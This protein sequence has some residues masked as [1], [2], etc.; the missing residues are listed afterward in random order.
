MAHDGSAV[1]DAAPLPDGA[2]SSANC[3]FAVSGDRTYPMTDGSSCQGS[4]TQHNG[5][6]DYTINMATGFASPATMESLTFGL[7]VT[8]TSP[9]AVGDTWTVGQDGR[10]GNSTLTVIKG[11]TG[12]LWGTSDTDA[13][14]VKGGTTVTF[15]SVTKVMGTQNPQ[16]VFYLFDVTFQAALNGQSPGT[17]PL[18]VTGHFKVTSLPLGA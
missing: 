2:V 3:G 7:L 4:L 9:P 18:K 1:A 15:T 13:A 16:D 5:S 11:S 8:S 10:G 14:L 17:A 6:G 12:V